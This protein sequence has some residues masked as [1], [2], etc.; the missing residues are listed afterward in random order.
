[1]TEAMQ[2]KQWISE[3]V[4]TRWMNEEGEFYGAKADDDTAMLKPACYNSIDVNRIGPRHRHRHPDTGDLEDGSSAVMIEM[5]IEMQ[6][7]RWI[8]EHVKARWMLHALNCRR[9]GS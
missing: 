1:M 7:K 5:M 8:S 6:V 4:K 3:H 9:D 2:V